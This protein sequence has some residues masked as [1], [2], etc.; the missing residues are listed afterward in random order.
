MECIVNNCMS[1]REKNSYSP[2]LEKKGGRLVNQTFP[3]SQMPSPPR[4]EN[5][6]LAFSNHS[7]V[8]FFAVSLFPYST[9]TQ[10]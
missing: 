4:N 2:R 10:K 6:H 9:S 1:V 3:C 7:S 8:F 5:T